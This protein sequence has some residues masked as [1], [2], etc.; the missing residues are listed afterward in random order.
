M[1]GIPASVKNNFTYGEITKRE[2]GSSSVNV[3]NTERWASALGGSLMVLLGWSRRSA[4][5]LFFMLGGGYLLYRG[6]GG[7]CPLYRAMGINMAKRD[8]G[9]GLSIEK[10]VTVNRPIA[11]VYQ[12]WRNFQNLPRFMQHLATVQP[13]GPGRTH[14]VA[15]APGGIT[16]EWD[17]EMVEER[18]NE[19]IAWRSLPGATVDNRGVVYFSQAPAGRGVEV[20]VKLEYYPPGG[21]AGVAFAKLFNRVT[22]QQIKEDMRRFKQ[23]LEAGE[24][25]TTE[26]QPHGQDATEEE[27]HIKRRQKPLH[28]IKKDDAVDEA[29]WE[30]FPA[31][32]PP[33]KW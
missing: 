13:D 8:E 32:D 25:P 12:F 4:A 26:G 18:E 15:Q 5:G 9:T 11:E 16:F 33:A 21:I 22:A 17:A 14:W 27:E 29:V 10:T 7:S 28:T 19:V 24:I 23:V 1:T 20:K 3:A 2:N 31:S 30:S 6:L